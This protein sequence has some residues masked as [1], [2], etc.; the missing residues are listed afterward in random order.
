MYSFLQYINFN[1]LPSRYFGKE[2]GYTS[3]MVCDYHLCDNHR[4]HRQPISTRTYI[5]GNASK[6]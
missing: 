3:T 1:Q 5:C 4:V 6:P 2:L